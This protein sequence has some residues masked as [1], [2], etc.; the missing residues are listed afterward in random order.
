MRY[1]K[2]LPKHMQEQAKK[3]T[4]NLDLDDLFKS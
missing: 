1:I 2:L 4:P 3:L